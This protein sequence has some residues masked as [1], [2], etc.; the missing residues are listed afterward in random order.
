MLSIAMDMAETLADSE[1]HDNTVLVEIL[2]PADSDSYE[3]Q[4]VR[5]EVRA[6]VGAAESH[7]CSYRVSLRPITPHADTHLDYYY[8]PFKVKEGVAP[9]DID[10]NGVGWIRRDSPNSFRLKLWLGMQLLQQQF[11]AMGFDCCEI[12]VRFSC[13]IPAVRDEAV[14]EASVVYSLSEV[15]LNAALALDEDVKMGEAFVSPVASSEDDGP[16]TAE[17]PIINV[18]FQD[19]LNGTTQ[20]RLAHAWCSVLNVHDYSKKPINYLEIG[21]FHGANVLSVGMTFGSHPESR[22]YCVDPWADY[23]DYPEYKSQ[24]PHNYATFIGNVENS[25]QKNK[26]VVNRGYSH[27]E[28]PAFY[29]NFFDIIYIDGNHEPDVRT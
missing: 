22:L 4:Q 1:A 12:F 11:R 28:V 15:Q 9:M 23:E 29:D 13:S 21:T 19:L 26:I 18:F 24:Q 10:E 14:G 5:L 17:H 20:Y 6:V 2:K 27:S 8:P 16:S 7:N 3:A 25:G